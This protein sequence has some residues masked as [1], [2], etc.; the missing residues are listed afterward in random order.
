MHRS[1]AWLSVALAVASVTGGV[2]AQ[3]VGSPMPDKVEV[4]DFRQIP[5]N[6]WEALAGRTVLIEFFAYW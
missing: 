5:V 3:S 6:S 2:R 1:K 4:D